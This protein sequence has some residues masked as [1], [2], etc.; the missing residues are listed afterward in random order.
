MSVP[1]ADKPICLVSGPP[2]FVNP[3][4]SNTA[5]ELC[6]RSANQELM[7]AVS[8]WNTAAA[9]LSASKGIVPPVRGVRAGVGF[10]LSGR[11][12]PVL[13]GGHGGQLDDGIVAQRRDG[14]Q[15]HV[16]GA[17]HRPFIVLL[18]QDG[19]DEPGDGGLV[20][21]DADDLGAALDL[22][23][24]RFERIGRVDFRPVSPWGSSCRPARRFRP[25]HQSGEFWHFG[26]E[27]VGD[28]APLDTGGF[29]I[30]LGKGGADKGGDDAAALLAGIGQGIAHEVHTAALPGGMQYPRDGGFQTLMCVRD[31]Q[32]DAAQAA[33]GER[34]Q[35]VGPEGLRFG[36]ADL[37][38]QHLAAAVSVDRHRDDHRNRNDAPLRGT[39]T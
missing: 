38:A 37:H 11:V 21:E 3:V 8:L 6:S 32:L 33:T 9:V 12:W 30:V 34:A 7:A 39:F 22:A 20:G 17:L 29:G 5:V 2:I 31:H 36:G 15:R 1:F 14:F 26:S 13:S 24:E 16:A 25:V 35:E 10:A 19:T 23:V 27:L 18:Q 28:L 4:T